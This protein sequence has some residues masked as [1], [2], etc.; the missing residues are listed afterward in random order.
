MT[1]FVYNN[2]VHANIKKTS[3]ELLKNYATSFVNTFKN[4]TLKKT[5]LITKRVN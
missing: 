4:E 1:V 3:H 2:N 5:F